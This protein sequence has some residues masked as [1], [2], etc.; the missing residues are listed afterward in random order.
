[1]YARAI[2][3]GGVKIVDGERVNG[4]AHAV[5]LSRKMVTTHDSSVSKLR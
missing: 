4:F 1:M 5:T 2:I 3:G